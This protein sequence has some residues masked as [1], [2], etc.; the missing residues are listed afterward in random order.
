MEI[1]REMAF[2]LKFLLFDVRK[3]IGFYW[4]LVADQRDQHLKPHHNDIDVWRGD[5][6]TVDSIMAA[7]TG[8]QRY[9]IMVYDG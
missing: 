9:I 7:D 8:W 5:P 2:T 6:A 4:A 1:N 3:W